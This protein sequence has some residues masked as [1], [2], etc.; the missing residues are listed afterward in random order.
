M[1][2]AEDPS[3]EISPEITAVVE[4]RAGAAEDPGVEVSSEM[5]AVVVERRGGAAEFPTVEVTRDNGC[6]RK[7]ASSQPKSSKI[8]MLRMRC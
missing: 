1:Q 2:A 8:P 4:R 5:T 7:G 6:L 3:V